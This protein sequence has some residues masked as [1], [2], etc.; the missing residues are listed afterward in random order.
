M[1]EISVCLVL[2]FLERNLCVPCLVHSRAKSLCALSCSFS[3][4]IS[5]CPV[6]F[7]LEAVNY[8]NIYFSFDSLLT[9][10]YSLAIPEIDE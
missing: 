3:S 6:L 8:V 4:E 10:M 5:V 7:I 1:S 9:V 2:F